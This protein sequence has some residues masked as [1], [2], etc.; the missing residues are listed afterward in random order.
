MKKNQ[1]I[2]ILVFLVCIILI[3]GCKVNKEVKDSKEGSIENSKE[4]STESE[5][6]TAT[7]QL[8]N[9]ASVYCKE[10]GYD[11]EIRTDKES[12][13]YGVCIFLDGSECEEWA[14]YRG[15]CKPKS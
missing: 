2:L 6:S 10:Q 7:N 8:A 5:V 3:N 1:L 15:E 11:L 12:N 14:Y 4:K 9:P 13:Q